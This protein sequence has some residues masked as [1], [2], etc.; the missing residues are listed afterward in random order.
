MNLEEA[1]NI[2]TFLGIED[3]SGLWEITWESGLYEMPAED[4]IRLARSAIEELASEGMVKLYRCQEPGRQLEEISEADWG[5]V[6][7]NPDSWLEPTRGAASIR[8]GTTED[9][10]AAYWATTKD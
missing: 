8:F 9:G 10:K 2:I 7:S 6:L 5:R 1:R 3:F 4:R